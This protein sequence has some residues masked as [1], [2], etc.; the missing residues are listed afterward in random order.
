MWARLKSTRVQ[1]NE[2]AFMT[3]V[4]VEIE[5]YDPAR[6]DGAVIQSR[7]FVFNEDMLTVQKMADAVTWYGN[8]LETILALIDTLPTDGFEWELPPVQQP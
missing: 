5:F 1:A 2:A 4:V 3:Q 8:S 6:D 7:E